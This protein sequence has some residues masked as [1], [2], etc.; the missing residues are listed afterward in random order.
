MLTKATAAAESILLFMKLIYL[1][2]ISNNNPQIVTPK[3][4]LSR[5][6]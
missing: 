1:N 5:F 3:T 2:K 4:Y 6:N